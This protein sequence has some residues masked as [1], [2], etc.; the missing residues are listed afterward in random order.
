MLE[1]F[2]LFLLGAAIFL[3]V[4]LVV[5]L[6]K[7]AFK[8]LIL[9]FTLVGALFKGVAALIVLPILLLVVVP[10]ALGVGAVL[11]PLLLLGLALAFV[12]LVG[13]ALCGLVSVV[14]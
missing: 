6:L 4:A 2:G 13:F 8:L 12:A 11:V 9:P 5:G 7:L 14:T 10:V 3:G 1:L